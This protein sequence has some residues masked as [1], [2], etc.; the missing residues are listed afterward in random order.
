M[1][2]RP[3]AR[4]EPGAGAAVVLPVGSRF[5]L[6]LASV[7]L[8]IAWLVEVAR[9]QPR[10]HSHSRPQTVDVGPPEA[11]AAQVAAAVDSDDSF[12]RAVE[13][14][15][16]AA[17]DPVGARGADGASSTDG[18]NAVGSEPRDPLATDGVSD[19]RTAPLPSEDGL[20]SERV[21]IV[22]G[23]VL[24]AVSG[25]R[26]TEH[27]VDVELVG[28]LALIQH[29]IRFESSARVAAEV[30]YALPVPETAAP[31]ALAV[32]S[33]ESRCREGRL[34]EGTGRTS[35]YDAAILATGPMREA[36]A[37]VAVLEL[38]RGAESAVL[39]LRA[40]P[41]PPT[42]VGP[43]AVVSRGALTVR[44][45]Y[46]VPTLV[47]GGVAR[48]RLPARGVDGRL[49]PTRIGIRAIDFVEPT[50][51]ELPVDPEE[52]IERRPERAIAIAAA[53][54][55]SWT[56]RIEAWTAPCG[57]D[58]CVLVHA[59]DE[60]PR[61]DVD[62]VVL[63]IDASPST[64]RGARGL[65]PEAA[66][67]LLARL[68]EHAR[69]RV[70][71]FAG[72]AQWIVETPTSPRAIEPDVLVAAAN[73]DLGASTR[74]EALFEA[75]SQATR[76]GRVV[77]VG[78]GGL[79]SSDE[80]RRAVERARASRLD[81]RVVSVADR[82]PV[83]AL[84]ALATALGAPIVQ[85]HAEALAASRGASR[86]PLEERLF[87]ALSRAPHREVR[88]LRASELRALGDSSLATVGPRVLAPGGA[89]SLVGRTSGRMVAAL[90]DQRVEPRAVTDERA[91]AV[92]ALA[93]RAPR[94]VAAEA[95]PEAHFC[96]AGA[97]S[98]H[99]STNLPRITPL[100]SQLARVER[101][102]CVSLPASEQPAA[103][104]SSR[105]SPASLLR[106]LRRR[107][108][109]PARACFRSDRRGRG[110]YSTRLT[111]V[112]A[113]ADREIVDVRAEGVIEP[114][115]AACMIGAVESLDVP[116]FDGVVVARWPLYTRPEL[117]P[118]TLD[119]HPDLAAA[120]DALARSTLETAP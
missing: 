92:V 51:D 109:P 69:V 64:A 19:L 68:P 74:F 2:Q 4:L 103:P 58:Q 85:A 30:G 110:D 42:A 49:A 93:S 37:P 94:L 32:C 20:P 1:T 21:P 91:A 62:D 11:V 82:T 117:A 59:R 60:R 18:A 52:T 7:A 29:E 81:L 100:P 48:L 107:I 115:L 83:G 72:R 67:A 14:D 98:L 101:R 34:D 28:G 88:V 84:V 99:P 15:P 35:S 23:A 33:A 116:D 80:G 54:P 24:Q 57:G 61:V 108:V 5:V 40:A 95:P 75:L 3:G 78:D 63:A 44:F 46:A 106:E 105:L 43:D 10:A 113:L 66:M 73:V 65:I 27:R 112:I 47:H 102:A 70:L 97:E 41:I 79:T 12:R 6:L 119:I 76:I 13:S 31:Y 96:S 53:T 114:S 89:L 16:F 120:I 90:D 36:S 39:R 86:A 104:R 56:P 8:A 55:R 25:V 118:P 45:A 38:E 87:A 22:R 17:E 71:A 9:G 50:I 111:L 77:W 26:E